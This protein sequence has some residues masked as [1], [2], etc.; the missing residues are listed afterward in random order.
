M[1]QH[2]CADYVL[3]ESSGWLDASFYG[4]WLLAA[5]EAQRL[6]TEAVQS[7]LEFRSQIDRLEILGPLLLGTEALKLVG[8]LAE[9]VRTLI[10]PV[11][12]DLGDCVALLARMGFFVRT[13]ERYQMVLP[14]YLDGEMVKG[15]GLAV[16]PWQPRKMTSMTFILSG[17]FG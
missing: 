13:G 4:R 5:A 14:R 17:C 15:A 16:W 9:N 1:N 10:V 8:K 11:D 12:S 2:S 6:W 3:I 7:D